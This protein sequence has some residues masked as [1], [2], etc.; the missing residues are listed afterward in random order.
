MVVFTGFISKAGYID[1]LGVGFEIIIPS[2][3]AADGFI[4]SEETGPSLASAG[5][6]SLGFGASVFFSSF[7]SSSFSSSFAVSFL[8]TVLLIEIISSSTGAA[9]FLGFF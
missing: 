1:L 4:V 2:V 8:A 3:D 7:F 6:A 5:G 9:F